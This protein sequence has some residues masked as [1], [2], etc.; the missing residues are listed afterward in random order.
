M[1]I[2]DYGGGVSRDTAILGDNVYADNGQGCRTVWYPS[3]EQARRVITALGFTPNGRDSGLCEQ[4][5][6]HYSYGTPEWGKYP[7]F[8]CCEWK[9]KVARGEIVKVERR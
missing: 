1:A 5:S 8:A 4:C 6:C 2:I 7:E 3:V 9:E